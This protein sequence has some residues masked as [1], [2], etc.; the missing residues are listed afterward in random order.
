MQGVLLV[1][2]GTPVS[3]SVKDV[4]KYLGEFLMDPRVMD[5]N[6]LLRVLLV[7]GIIAPF[8]GRSSAKLY[9]Q[10]WDK[11]TGSPLLY[12]SQLQQYH[13][14]K[15]LGNGYKV[16]LAMRYQEP[17]IENGLQKLRDA[18]V[19]S[20]KVIAMFPQYASATTGSV[21]QKVMEVVGKWQTIP[22]MSF[23]N[24]FHDNELMINAFAAN[25]CKHMPA[26]YDHVLFSFHG[27]P[28]RHVAKAGDQQLHNCEAAG[29]RTGFTE[30]NRFCYVAQCYHTARLIAKK[31]MIPEHRYTVCFQSR[32]GND[33]W[34]KPY[35]S[36]TIIHLA[37]TGKK[38]LL[39]FCPA[40]VAD[41]LETLYEVAIEYDE[42]FK[43]AG[44]EHIQLVESL[45]ASSLFTNALKEIVEGAGLHQPYSLCL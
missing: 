40:F 34:I 23:V 11:Q 10:I 3:C 43:A 31:A 35:A 8:R 9:R 15:E 29:C 20:I 39:V 26:S 6:P 17:S 21:H 32:L 37:K 38:R 2:L 7:G 18:G 12:Y 45:N 30:S 24:S 33:P 22:D 14:Q 4:R 19:K 16:E 5:I 27:L 36:E 44:G 28:Q 42:L 13:L 25:G 41:C 1:N